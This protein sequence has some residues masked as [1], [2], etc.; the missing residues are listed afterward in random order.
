[1]PA[2]PPS[3]QSALQ[4]SAP[5]VF[6]TL[7]EWS[8]RPDIV[9]LLKDRTTSG[10]MAR[11]EMISVWLE[12]DGFLTI[13]AFCSAAIAVTV[14]TLAETHLPI[15]VVLSCL[16]VSLLFAASAYLS[17]WHL[18]RRY[19]LADAD[20]FIQ[21]CSGL[22][23]RSIIA[24]VVLKLAPCISTMSFV[25]AIFFAFLPNWQ[26]LLIGGG[27]CVVIL[28]AA[29]IHPWVYRGFEGLAKVYKA[30]KV[31]CVVWRD[32][33]REDALPTHSSANLDQ[34]LVDA[35]PLRSLD[36]ARQA[37]RR[38]GADAGPQSSG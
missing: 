38:R 2:R 37:I 17:C 27:V 20:A 32:G 13:I 36:L 12:R 21:L 30:V 15:W 16:V 7:L 25:L 35:V 24:P 23:K 18:H 10:D 8:V 22:H 14:P 29:V 31:A 9:L 4:P 26:P 3:V 34:I 33:A 11:R 5:S 19:D 28:T 1:M 6:V